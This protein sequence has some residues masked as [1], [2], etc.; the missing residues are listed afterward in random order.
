M[1]P[2]LLAAAA[3]TAG[4]PMW[5]DVEYALI[6]VGVAVLLFLAWAFSR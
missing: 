1:H 2:W 5:P 4:H 6:G 3:R